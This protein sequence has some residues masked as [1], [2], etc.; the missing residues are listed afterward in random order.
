MTAVL[1]ELSRVIHVHY[2]APLKEADRVQA[3]PHDVFGSS[4]VIGHHSE[5][6]FDYPSIVIGRKGSV[7]S[8]TYAPR[9]GW[10]IDTAFFVER[11]NPESCHLRYL[12]HALS[13]ANL[14]RHTITTSIPGLSRDDIYRTP[15]PLPTPS[16]QRRIADILDK[17]D[18]IRRKRKEAIALTEELLRSTFLEMF[19]DPVT[20]PKGWEVKPLGTLLSIP[21]RNGLSPASGGIHSAKLLTLS[22]IT[23]GRFDIRAVKDGLFAVEPWSDVRLDE[24]DFLICRG[25]GNLSLVGVGAFPTA[26]DQTVVFP[27]TMIAARFDE[28]VI[29]R[30]FLTSVWKSAFVRRQLQSGARTTNGTFKVNQSVIESVRIPVPDCEQQRSFEAVAHRVSLLLKSNERAANEA[31]FL[32]NSL[33]S[34]AFTSALRS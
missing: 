3:G 33:V 24:R 8:V 26:S 32:F 10:A 30:S 22:A 14:A 16:E 6:L 28:A 19:G 17:A 11:I 5:T 13:A 7:G 1:V 12:Y 25:N 4:G 2:G 34:R 23:R 29:S 18:A 15:I 20:N 31:E 21:L 27:D 9:G